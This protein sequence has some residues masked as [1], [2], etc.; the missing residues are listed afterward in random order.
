M[1]RTYSWPY[2]VCPHCKFSLKSLNWSCGLSDRNSLSRVRSFY[3]LS[4]KNAQRAEQIECKVCD[5]FI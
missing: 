5:D 3:S 2:N 4:E 1:I